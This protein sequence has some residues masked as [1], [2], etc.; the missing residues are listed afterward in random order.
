MNQLRVRRVALNRGSHFRYCLRA[1]HRF[2]NDDA[3]C[4]CASARW[5]LWRGRVPSFRFADF[6]VVLLLQSTP[7]CSGA[8][9]E[10]GS[11]LS[12]SLNW[13]AARRGRLQQI[14][15]DGVDAAPYRWRYRPAGFFRTG[16]R[17]FFVTP[18]L[19]RRN[20]DCYARPNGRRE[21]T[22]DGRLSMAR[23]LSAVR[24]RRGELFSRRPPM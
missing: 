1:A 3:E 14:G 2:G 22:D 16:R 6:Q 5:D 7:R 17:P 11:T 24:W 13:A 20:R 23:A 18:L 12:T 4:V 8:M 9:A 10:L 19:P 21:G 15:E